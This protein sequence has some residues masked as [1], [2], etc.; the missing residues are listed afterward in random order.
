M[1]ALGTTPFPY[2]HPNPVGEHPELPP[3]IV[4]S[5]ERR[6]RWRPWNAVLALIAGLV[7][8]LFGAAVIGVVAAPFGASLS[9][10]PG[11]VTI[12]GTIWQDVCFIGSALF[13]A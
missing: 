10:P 13:F 12:L 3:G 7:A 2:S 1:D 4:P 5:R 11:S 9:D 8:A 6:P